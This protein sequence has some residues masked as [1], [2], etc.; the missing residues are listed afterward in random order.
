V[1]RKFRFDRDL[2]GVTFGENAVIAAGVGATLAVGDT[3]NVVREP[4]L[5]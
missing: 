4:A 1:L 5:T 2:M 3:C